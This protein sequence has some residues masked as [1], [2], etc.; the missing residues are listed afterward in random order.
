MPLS[1]NPCIAFCITCKGRVQHLEKTLPLNLPDNA[2][3][4]NCKFIVLDYNSQDHLIPY[5]KATHQGAI[6]S[7]KLVVYSYREETPFRVAHAKNM[8]HRLGILEGADI[9]VNLDADNFTGPG[10]AQ[11]IAEQF[12][13]EE[14]I[15]L[16]ARMIQHGEDRLPRGINGRL[17]VPVKAFLHVGGYD[18]RFAVWS[19]DDK[20][21]NLRLR[22]L[23]YQA[24]E[25]DR[26]FLNCVRHND[27][28]RFKHNSTHE[29]EPDLSLET[30]DSSDTT[31]VN[32]GRIGVGTVYRN[33]CGFSIELR[34]LPT[35]I[36]G[37][38]MHK[39]AT[40]SLHQAF[41]ILGYD[42]AHW[43]TAHWAKEIWD[44]M[45][46][47]GRSITL[48]KSYALCDLPLPLLYQKLDAA[49]PGSKFVLTIR[50]EER[51]LSSVRNHWN[52]EHNKFRSA[53]DTDPF[54]HRVHKLLY[55]QKEFDAEVFLS[56]YRRH[57][58]EVREYF[59]DRPQDLLVMNMDRDAGWPEL[60]GF[61][62]K[63]IPPVA[64]PRAF[65][66]DANMHVGDRVKYSSEWPPSKRR[67]SVEGVTLAGKVKVKW[68]GSHKAEAV[69]PDYVAVS[70]P[71][72]EDSG[73][74]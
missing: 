7:G 30:V 1:Q 35:R 52:R 70:L 32:F 71:E 74:V 23:G 41:K 62:E 42:S 16:W 13:S 38:G 48:E 33:L 36:F 55:G 50:N 12:R 72:G 39:T 34:P 2:D 19:P 66:T 64:Y 18:E 53:W 27:K 14:D 65:V 73:D 49:Y 31:V 3:Y 28:M 17:V 57:N 4:D 59:R 6:D 40:T 68:D 51:W 5:L 29:N 46:S 56:R 21:F 54:S 24:R 10:F 60:C 20:D 61:L 47:W 15:F 69:H 67:G 63:P 9:L 37:I 22:R 25:I 11:F 26:R 8:A 45:Q 44:E 43:K 58:A